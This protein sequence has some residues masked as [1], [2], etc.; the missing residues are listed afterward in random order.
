MFQ[1]YHIIRN[2][3]FSRDDDLLYNTSFLFSAIKSIKL[4]KNYLKNCHFNIHIDY[5]NNLKTSYILVAD[6]TAPEFIA[7]S[8]AVSAALL[9]SAAFVNKLYIKPLPHKHVYDVITETKIGTV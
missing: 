7:S 1:S 3:F 2:I 9:R 6:A 5:Y 8:I 4:I